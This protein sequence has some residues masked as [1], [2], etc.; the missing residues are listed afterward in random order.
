MLIKEYLIND[1]GLFQCSLKENP[2]QDK[3]KRTHKITCEITG[4]FER[5]A[6]ILMDPEVY[7]FD[8][9]NEKGE[10]TWPEKA[11]LK[12][13]L[14]P[15][16]N[17]KIELNSEPILLGNLGSYVNPINN[18]RKTVVD[19]ALQ[20]LPPRS[21]TAKEKMLTAMQTAKKSYS[22]T[23]IESAYLVY[24]WEYKNFKYDCYN[25]HRD[26]SKIDYTEEGTYSKGYGVC[27]GFAKNYVSLCNAM[28]FEAY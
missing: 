4:S 27:D 23:Q 12:T 11:E 9:L 26:K 18:V 21:Q 5:R 1:F 24:K 17:K 13:F 8:F 25:Y 14:I 6:Y 16:C 2:E 7:G 3:E 15:E 28:G 19:Q 22:L 20:S 10:T